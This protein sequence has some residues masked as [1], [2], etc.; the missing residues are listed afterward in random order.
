MNA[1]ASSARLKIL[2]FVGCYLPGYKGGGPV[3]TV[4]NMVD[5]LSDE[6]E[7]WIVTRDRDLGDASPYAA[8]RP[9]RWQSVGAAMVCYVP[10]ENRTLRE[11]AALVNSTQHDVMYFNSFFEPHFTIKP[12]LARRLGWLP[13]KPVVVAPRG[14]FSPG[15][16]ALK[17]PKKCLYIQVAKLLRLYADVTWHASSAHEVRDIV[18][19]LAQDVLNVW[20]ASPPTIHMA[21]DLPTRAGMN[22]PIDASLPREADD[23]DL[24]IVFLSRISPMKNLD[25]A[26]RVL[27]KVK[28]AVLFDV[29]GPA[30]DREYWNC[31]KQLMKRLPA[32]VSVKY[33][34]G[35]PSDRVASTIGRYDLLFLPTRGENY[36]HVIAEA[37][38]AGTPVLLSDQ[39]PWRN[40]QADGMGWDIPLADGDRF[41]DAIDELAATTRRERDVSRAHVRQRMAERLTDPQI[42]EANRELFRRAVRNHKGLKRRSCA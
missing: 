28:A 36:G 42:D 22:A 25:Y 10:P 31:C 15:A 3:R 9:N 8:V 20:S 7:F 29:Y 14:E 6:F 13:D 21:S 17:R 19:V 23:A 24:R 4:A 35:V 16:M 27:C 37:L 18:R 1:D 40:L 33:W 2:T 5:L 39:T 41:A 30:E 34:G 32:N 11:L 38:S 26:L 12:L